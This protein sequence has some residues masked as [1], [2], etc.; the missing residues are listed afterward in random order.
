MFI[1]ADVS[2]NTFIYWLPVS[3]KNKTYQKFKILLSNQSAV[4]FFIMSKFQ[5]LFVKGDYPA[6]QRQANAANAVLYIEQHFNGGSAEASYA[7]ANVGTNSGAKSK[8]IAKDYVDEICAAFGVKAANND[9]ATGGVS[10]GGYKGRG[11]GNLTLTNMP[12]VLLEPLFATN[13]KYAEIIRSEDGQRNLASCL[14]RTIKRNFPQGGLIAFSVGHKYK[15]SEP[16]DRGV[17]L[18]GGGTE[19]DYAEKVLLKAKEMLES[20]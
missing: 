19:A 11:N 15:T 18:A 10:V 13:P 9:F 7:L 2:K 20:N 16:A 4:G 17:A 8:S 3:R 1:I 6:R 14:V 12:A 5:T